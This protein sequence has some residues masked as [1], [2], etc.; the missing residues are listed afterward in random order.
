VAVL[1]SV[2]GLVT[3]SARARCGPYPSPGQPDVRP[4]ADQRGHAVG[5]SRWLQVVPGGLQRQTRR[6]SVAFGSARAGYPAR[7]CAGAGD[8]RRC[9]RSGAVVHQWPTSPRRTRTKRLPRWSRGGDR[10]RLGQPITR[11]KP[12]AGGRTHRAVCR[13]GIIAARACCN[14]RHL[15]TT[16]ARPDARSETQRYVPR[17]DD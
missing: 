2:C 13:R 4:N 10:V 6:P 5:V 11:R 7:R 15:L 1:S 3:T 9:H 12:T 14:R 17:A 16:A 8:R